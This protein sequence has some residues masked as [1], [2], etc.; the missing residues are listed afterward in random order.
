MVIFAVMKF[1]TVFSENRSFLKVFCPDECYSFRAMLVMWRCVLQF[2]PLFSRVSPL[3]AFY[4]NSIVRPIPAIG[5]SL[6]PLN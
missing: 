2:Y 6:F 3:Y 4:G 1:F 5:F